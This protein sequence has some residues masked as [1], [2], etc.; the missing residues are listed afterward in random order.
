MPDV[1]APVVAL[2]RRS[3]EPV[4]VQTLR[5]TTAAVISYV[6]A[7][8]LLPQPAP[9]TAPLTA[10]LVVQ[11]TLYATLT[12][13]I[14]RMNAVL[15]GVLIA[16]GFSTLVGLSWW[17][18]GLTIVT[19]LTIG[20]LVRVE[21]FVPEVAISAMLVLGVS[22]VA[23]TA[24]DRIFE[25]LIGAVVGMLFNLFLAPPVWVQTAEGSITAMSHR[26][27]GLF[28]EMADEVDGALP[29]ERAA[30]RL[31]ASRRLDNDIAE[32]DAALR[33]A[34]ESTRLNPRVREGALSRVVLRTA[35][36]T[37]EICAVVQRVMF[38]SFTDLA[39]ARTGEPLFPDDV[40]DAL[41]LLYRQMAVAVESFAAL[42]TT[43]QSSGADEAEEHLTRALADSHA[44]REDLAHLLLDDVL[45]H[46]REWQLHGAILAE[47]DRVLDE[48]DVERRSARLVDE[49]DRLSREQ[50]ERHPR[51]HA[52]LRRLTE[53]TPTAVRRRG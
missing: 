25:T 44:A 41:R 23:A 15:A 47:A 17:S 9:L 2:V 53:A 24:W 32:V 38:R 7:V 10:L 5:S 12:T 37:L 13:G 4:V 6:I 26:M 51:L 45:E 20:R 43:A 29:V 50:R 8:T 40:A 27:A 22:Q 46:P 36:D 21:Q 48:L 49:L 11:V 52:V 30:A 31:H 35:L 1:P 18:L 28:R 19:A 33:Q 42:I 14:R 3:T 39:K 34:E 16:S